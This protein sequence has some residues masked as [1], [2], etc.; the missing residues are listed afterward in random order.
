MIIDHMSRG[1]TVKEFAE[2]LGVSTNTI[3]QWAKKYPEFMDAK[4]I[5][6]YHSRMKLG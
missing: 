3:A 1:K 2:K 5:G 6:H 4:D